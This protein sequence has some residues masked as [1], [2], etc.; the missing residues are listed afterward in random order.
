L[1]KPLK[2][3][4]SKQF[5]CSKISAP[6][7][8]Y[9]KISYDLIGQNRAAALATVAANGTPHVATVYCI[10]EPDLT[11]Y[12]V[13]R[14]EARKY[15]NL[16]FQPHVAMTF[17]NEEHMESVQLM[18]RAERVEVLADE[19]DRLYEL[20]VLRHGEHNWPSPPVKL[21]HSGASSELAVIRVTPSELTYANFAT[22]SSGCYKPFFQK[23]L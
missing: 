8:D 15:K 6:T 12:F 19:Q 7:L 18:G 2:S 22:A 11:I 20:M 1:L 21:Y 10:V 13:T 23:V 3:K 16:V 9:N 4:S 17:T 5:S 14:I